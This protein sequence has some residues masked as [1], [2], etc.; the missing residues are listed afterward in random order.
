MIWWR[1][2][3]HNNHLMGFQFPMVSVR[4]L[5]LRYF[6]LSE[7]MGWEVSWD[8]KDKITRENSEGKPCCCWQDL[9]HMCKMLAS[10]ESES[11]A[12]RPTKKNQSVHNIDLELDCVLHTPIPKNGECLQRVKQAHRCLPKNCCLLHL[13][14]I[15]FWSHYWTGGGNSSW[16]TSNA[17]VIFPVPG[18]P[19]DNS[20]RPLAEKF[21]TSHAFHSIKIILEGERICLADEFCPRLIIM[22][23]SRRRCWCWCG[24]SVPSS[25]PYAQ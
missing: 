21:A 8:T 24:P 25:L 13:R 4:S 17:W 22:S 16:D 19:T 2:V 3:F 20:A 5:H 18:A 9:E 23:W 12:E 15:N 10:L 14:A 1:L 7:R 11:R 6:P